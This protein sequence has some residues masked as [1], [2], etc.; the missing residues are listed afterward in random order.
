[1]GLPWASMGVRERPCAL[2]CLPRG[3]IFLSWVSRTLPWVSPGSPMGLPW[4]S[5][6]S[7]GSPVG[8]HGSLKAPMC[9]HEPLM[10][11]HWRGWA[12]IGLSWA[13]IGVRGHL[14][15]LVGLPWAPLVVLPW[16]AFASLP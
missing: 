11:V 4:T 12:S 16:W 6:A 3:I 15:A 14:W 5:I 13:P 1:M 7:C 2:M 10:G 9:V 8:V